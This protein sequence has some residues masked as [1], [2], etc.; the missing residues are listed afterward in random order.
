[1]RRIR[2]IVAQLVAARRKRRLTQRQVAAAIGVSVT[3]LSR[4]EHGST[5]PL[6][7]H[8]AAWAWA[9]GVTN[10]VINPETWG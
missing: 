5:D 2:P 9:V 3:S 6:L 4:W 8:V 1:M 7:S 10:L